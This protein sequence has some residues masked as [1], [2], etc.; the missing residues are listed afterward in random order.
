MKSVTLSRQ[1]GLAEFPDAK[2]ARGAKHLMELAELAGAGHRAVLLF[3]VQRGDCTRLA[4]RRRY[5]S[6]L[7]AALDQARNR[8]VEVIAVACR[9]SPKPLKSMG[10]FP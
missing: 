2:T 8:D 10:R 9:L 7:A 4:R 3:L 5:R 6:R 1:P